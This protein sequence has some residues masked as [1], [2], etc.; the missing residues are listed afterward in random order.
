VKIQNLT[1]FNSQKP[2]VHQIIFK[3]SV[4]TSQEAMHHQMVN[5]V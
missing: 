1:Q 5:T 3:I 4:C 2:E